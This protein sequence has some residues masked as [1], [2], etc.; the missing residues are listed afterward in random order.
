MT[1]LNRPNLIARGV[2]LLA[3]AGVVVAVILLAQGS[4]TYKLRLQMS[5]A[6]GVRNG[7]QVLLGGVPVGSV[8]SLDLGP[9]DSVI[10]TLNLNP[11]Q[12]R[13]GQ[14]ASA[15]IIAAN[16]LGE[17][18]VSLN[19]GDPKQPLP[20]G[21]L[22][23]PSRITLPT[24]LDQIVN[25]FDASTRERL[26]IL[27]NE[28]GI[29]VAG[30]RSDVSAILRQLPLSAVA[31]TKLLDQL[32]QDNHTLRDTVANS[33][34]FIARINAAE[35]RPR[36]R[37][38]RRLG[39]ASTAAQEAANLSQTLIDAPRTLT[40]ARRFLL[41]AGQ[42]SLD[43]TPAAAQIG[44]S[45]GPLNTLL[46]QVHPF[47]QAAVPALNRA[48]A[49]APEL[50]RLAVK[51]TPIIRQAVP[52]V[53]ALSNLVTLAKPLTHWAGLSVVD[54]LAAIQGWSSGLQFRDG[55][56]HVFHAEL[57]LSPGLV[58]NL[59]SWR[60]ALARRRATPRARAAGAHRSGATGPRRRSAH[61]RSGAV[62]DSGA[63]STPG[64]AGLLHGLSG[65]LGHVLGSV[66]GGGSAASS[67]SSGVVARIVE[68]VQ[69]PQL[70]AREMSRRPGRSRRAPR[71]RRESRPALVVLDGSGGERGDR[72]LHLDRGGVVQRTAVHQL[73]EPVRIAA[74][75][76]PPRDSRLGADRRR[77]GRPGAADEHR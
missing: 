8:G 6:N 31:G 3:L 39:G 32:V 45:A 50:T 40:T 30:R 37:D 65:V 70:P 58:A 75:H 48:A 61:E 66:A 21:A 62:G 2:T 43:L 77:Q 14:G 55:L 54:L 69:P 57:G 11:K 64:V 17:E 34:Q 7:S 20:S 18:Y 38:R 76:R 22:V 60:A 23:P 68:P 47:E 15:S 44:A 5:N 71:R 42:T 46:T 35:G 19:P 53:T 74:E 25:V 29:A 73:Q 26:A 24:A 72:R 51:G 12:V 52:T 41:S 67:A 1:T 49:V 63:A 28:M 4:P 16:L 10:A 56:G 33:N 36:P 27:I 9:R 59:A 13:I